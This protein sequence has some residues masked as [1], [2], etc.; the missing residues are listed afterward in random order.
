MNLEALTKQLE[1]AESQV[2]NIEKK[3]QAQH[4]VLFD[5]NKQLQQ[6]L[7]NVENFENY[8]YI[9]CGEFNNEVDYIYDASVV[10]KDLN[11]RE[12]EFL[13]EY[14]SDAFPCYLNL[15]EENIVGS[16]IECNFITD[17]H[18]GHNVITADGKFHKYYSEFH[19]FLLIE[20]SME[21]LGC[22]GGVYNV[23]YYGNCE[24]FKGTNVTQ[25][26]ARYSGKDKIE[27]I[28]TLI[29]YCEAMQDNLYLTIDKS[30]EDL[31]IDS[32]DLH[33]F[34]MTN[35]NDSITITYELNV[36]EIDDY[37][38][39]YLKDLKKF[40]VEFSNIDDDSVRM[41]VKKTIDFK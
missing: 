15:K 14:I 16:D 35:T 9:R 11:N 41:I 34:H 1:V 2:V 8:D 3:M 24:P 37:A 18:D 19:A 28:D 12:K 23:D 25:M 21:E 7:T 39:D 10:L 38:E 26:I 27:K 17:S 32:D 13:S 29:D 31:F 20:K 40:G 33:D 5:N 4:N 36:Y 6:L 30:I 22:F